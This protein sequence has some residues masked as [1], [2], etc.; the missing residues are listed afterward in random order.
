VA[1]F[2]TEFNTPFAR[3]SSR[4]F[5]LGSFASHVIRF[6]LELAVKPGQDPK[7]PIGVINHDLRQRFSLVLTKWNGRPSHINLY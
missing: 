4:T 5:N 3:V 1:V 2:K 7:K 6:A